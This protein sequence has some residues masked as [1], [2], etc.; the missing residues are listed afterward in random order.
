MLVPISTVRC[1][2]R[3]KCDIPKLALVTLVEVHRH[4]KQFLNTPSDKIG[5]LRRRGRAF[6]N[7]RKL[8]RADATLQSSCIECGLY[9]ES[10]SKFDPFWNIVEVSKELIVAVCVHVCVCVCVWLKFECVFSM[11]SS[12][13]RNAFVS[14]AK[15][16]CLRTS[17]K[18][19][20]CY[21][22]RICLQCDIVFGGE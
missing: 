9:K 11:C 22:K 4:G 7:C 19:I 21:D 15:S 8:K 14:S 10:S 3:T 12:P 6:V 2:Q 20:R 5:N 13:A 16:V 1:N 18:C 17:T